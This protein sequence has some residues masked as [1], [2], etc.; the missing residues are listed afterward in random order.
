MRRNVFE[1]KE[2]DA[3]ELT[4]VRINLWLVTIKEQV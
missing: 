1:T 4:R 2:S 3:I